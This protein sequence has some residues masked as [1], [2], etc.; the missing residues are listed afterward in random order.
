[1]SSLSVF[2]SIAMIKSGFLMGYNSRYW[3]PWMPALNASPVPQTSPPVVIPSSPLI[4]SSQTPIV[5]TFSLLPNLERAKKTTM[6]NE[7]R[8]ALVKLCLDNQAEH[9]TVVSLHFGRR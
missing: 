8:L 9:T 2:H 4:P 5:D 3:Q 6:N 1:M 7:V